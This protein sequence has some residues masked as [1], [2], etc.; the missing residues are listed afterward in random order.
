MKK[1]TIIC[2]KCGMK[3]KLIGKGGDITPR[4]D[5]W[6][7]KMTCKRGYSPKVSIGCKGCKSRETIFKKEV[8]D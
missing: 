1:F 2:N 5:I 6:I 4:A 7:K 3:L 8:H